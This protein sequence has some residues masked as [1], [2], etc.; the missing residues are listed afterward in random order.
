MKYMAFGLLT[1]K[2]HNN[3]LMKL[4]H[5]KQ[6]R[7][8]PRVAAWSC[9]ATGSAFCGL[10][11]LGG[12]VFFFHLEFKDKP[13]CWTGRRWLFFGK[14]G[15]GGPQ[16]MQPVCAPCLAFSLNAS[17]KR[18]KVALVVKTFFRTFTL[19]LLLL[20]PFLYFTVPQ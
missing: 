16:T 3:I 19:W 6:N 10:T 4:W 12:G 5:I 11:A 2:M 13:F 17:Q 15:R 18:S 20:G 8:E 9:T 1:E 7:T 14:F